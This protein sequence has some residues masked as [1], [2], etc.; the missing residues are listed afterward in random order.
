MRTKPLF[1]RRGLIIG[2]GGVL[3]VIVPLIAMA[4]TGSGS[5]NVTT[6]YFAWRNS[7][8]STTSSH[9]ADIPN[10]SNILPSSVCGPTGASATLSV[11]ASGSPLEVRVIDVPSVGS[12][13]VMHPG[14]ARF[15]PPGGNASSFSFTF[16]EGQASL[17]YHNWSAQ[18]RLGTTGGSATLLS[19][20]LVVLPG[21]ETCF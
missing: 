10:L 15:V 1:R 17:A 16:V 4:A 8:I 2:L 5:T 3:V 11:E 21:D 12:S 14:A 6:Q 18:W 19:A 13:T 9:W 7:T 20:S